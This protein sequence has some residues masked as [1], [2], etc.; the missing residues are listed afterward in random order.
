[1][2]VHFDNSV[3]VSD[4]GRGIPVD[5]HKEEGKAAYRCTGGFVCAAQR[6]TRLMHFA[7][8]LAMDIEGLGE[9]TAKALLEQGLVR[10]GPSDLYQ[11]STQDLR[12]L[13]GFGETSAVNL[14]SA[15]EASR[16]RPFNRFLYALGIEGVGEATA[17]DL[18]RFFGSWDDFAR[19]NETALLSVPNLGPV[20][21]RNI[22]DFLNH[23]ATGPES[24]WLAAAIGPAAVE[25]PAASSAIAGKTFV[26]TGTLSVAREEIKAMNAAA[27]GKVSG[28]VS[29]KTD[30]LV[31]GEE[32][33]SKLAKARELG[34]AVWSEDDL[35]TTL[36]SP[37]KALRS[38]PKP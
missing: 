22:I 12:R 30:A 35:R 25:K 29:K 10:N 4:N 7:S 23:P 28:S 37:E 3:T 15:I 2:T 9:S 36:A 38:K 34:V 27:G 17:K 26:I 6:E 19:A 18:A 5:M 31:A 24:S 16:G 11:L 13:P 33:G 8:R 14:V 1:V 21:A 20:T 32:A